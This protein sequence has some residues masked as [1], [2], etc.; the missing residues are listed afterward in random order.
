MAAPTMHNSCNTNMG[1]LD[2]QDIPFG[3]PECFTGKTFVFSGTL[4][5][6]SRD[7]AKALVER[8]NGRV[9]G[10]VS[11]RSSFLVVGSNCSRRKYDKV[12]DTPAV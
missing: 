4:D 11:S 1:V 10:D 7:E 5:S 3:H 12:G 8:A 6:L 9:T 2:I